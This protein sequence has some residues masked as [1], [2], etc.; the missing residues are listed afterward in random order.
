MSQFY[1]LKIKNDFICPEP[2]RIL[3]HAI[4]KY[5]LVKSILIEKIQGLVLI[6]T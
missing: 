5:L 3:P 1:I 6:K 2:I 4:R